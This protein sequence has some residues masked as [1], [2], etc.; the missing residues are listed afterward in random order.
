MGYKGIQTDYLPGR[1]VPV[2]TY[3]T[4]GCKDFNFHF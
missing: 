1:T 3:E 2:K 4:P